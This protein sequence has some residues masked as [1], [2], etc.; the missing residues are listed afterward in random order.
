M[1]FVIRSDVIVMIGPQARA[2]HSF[3]VILVE[4]N[5]ENPF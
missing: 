4:P 2:G 1:T 3:F 5:L